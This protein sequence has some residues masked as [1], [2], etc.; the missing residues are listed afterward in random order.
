[1][2]AASNTLVSPVDWFVP[3]T[4]SIQAA[5]ASDS[6]TVFNG[7]KAE[8]KKQGKYAYFMKHHFLSPC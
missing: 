2:Y 3:K 5:K 7:E 4:L 6:S 8:E 1:L